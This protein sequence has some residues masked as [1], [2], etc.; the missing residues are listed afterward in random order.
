[1]FN[2]NLIKE[3]LEGHGIHYKLWPDFYDENLTTHFK[4]AAKTVLLKID[5]QYA[6][7][8]ISSNEHID[9][10]R[11]K[12]ILKARSIEIASEQECEALF[13]DCD[14]TALPAL[15]SLADIPV[16]CSQKVLADKE[17]CFNPGTH[18][19][20][21]KVPVEEFIRL[22][23]PTTGNFTISGYYET[24]YDYVY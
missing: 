1:M 16:Y 7:V 3:H 10:A 13:P 22:E 4:T 17:V 18:D 6:I 12:S 21:V 15:G 2:Q 20:I 14:T 19:K 23:K 11:M 8:V 9:L 24:E 5:E